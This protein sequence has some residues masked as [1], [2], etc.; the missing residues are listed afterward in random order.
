MEDCSHCIESKGLSTWVSQSN[1][2]IQMKTC[3]RCKTPIKQCMR[4]MNQIKKDMNDLQLVK[5]KVFGNQHELK[6]KQIGHLQTIQDLIKNPI[7]TGICIRL[8][9]HEYFNN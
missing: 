2:A 8:L 7:V 3:P 9:S 4:I 1:E 5:K 6:R